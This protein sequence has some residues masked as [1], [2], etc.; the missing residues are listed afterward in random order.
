[1]LLEVLLG[2]EAAINDALEREAEVLREHRI[3]EGIDGAVAVAEPE[4][5]GK[6]NFVDA[7]VAERANEV[8]REER[9]PAEN[10]HSCTERSFY[11]WLSISNWLS[12]QIN[13]RSTSSMVGLG[14]EKGGEEGENAIEQM[15]IIL[16][17]STREPWERIEYSR[18]QKPSDHDVKPGWGGS[19]LG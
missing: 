17:D 13:R 16:M 9:Q 15:E 4:Q 18:G 14:A 10:E 5:N 3:N 12:V 11:V 2:A 6:Q 8:E 19:F 1:M 7:V